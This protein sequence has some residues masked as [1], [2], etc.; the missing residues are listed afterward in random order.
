VESFA[1]E[2]TSLKLLASD[3][4]IGVTFTPMLDTAQYNELA[5]FVIQGKSRTRQ[6]F[7]DY[8]AQLAA[9]WGVTF[10]PEFH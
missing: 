3:G 8:F 10:T 7:C 5:E 1:V 6:E 9:E 2:E 4:P